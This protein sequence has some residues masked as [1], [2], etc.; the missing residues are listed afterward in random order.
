MLATASAQQV[1]AQLQVRQGSRA[2]LSHQIEC[3]HVSAQAEALNHIAGKAG[4]EVAGAGADHNRVNGCR[5][6]P[7]VGQRPPRRL[8]GE[9]GRVS[10]KPGCQRVRIDL[11]NLV[12]RI[13]SQAA[14]VDAV[15]P[16][17]HGVRDETR[18]RI[19]L[20]V[21]TGFAK[22]QQALCLGVAGGRCGG[23]HAPQERLA[24]GVTGLCRRACR[25]R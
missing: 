7:G 20:A 24:R 18:P 13:H 3:H 19:E 6:D 4:T 9:G 5:I 23:A 14:L 2:A 1:V 17:K 25:Q 10:Q 15:V 21:P 22:R 8:G 12:Q 16:L 11:E